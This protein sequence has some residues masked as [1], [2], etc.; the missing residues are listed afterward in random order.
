MV[1]CY[2]ILTLSLTLTLTLMLRIA[3]P[4]NVYNIHKKWTAHWKTQCATC[5]MKCRNPPIVFTHICS[6]FQH[7]ISNK[8]FSLYFPN[9]FPDFWSVHWVILLC[10]CYF[11]NRALIIWNS[12]PNHVVLSDTVNTF[13]S[14]L[15]KFWHHQDVIYDVT[16][17]I[18]GTGSR[19]CY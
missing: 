19:S 8:Q 2:V 1:F 17:K 18:R 11:T 14:R 13:K 7:E 12:L 10:K 9:I 6:H 4:I 3:D 15:D 5:R 16:A